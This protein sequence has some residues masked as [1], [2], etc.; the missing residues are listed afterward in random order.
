MPQDLEIE[1]DDAKRLKTLQERQ[2]DFA[3]AYQVFAGDTIMR[4]DN[5]HDYGE[6]RIIPLGYL[7]HRLVVLVWTWRGQ[8]RRIISMRHANEREI[9]YFQANM[10]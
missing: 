10:G 1:Y 3:H 4:I 8:R 6:E 2:L 5:R 9:R 7:N